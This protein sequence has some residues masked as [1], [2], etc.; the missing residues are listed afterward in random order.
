MLLFQ[1]EFLHKF[2]SDV[3]DHVCMQGEPHCTSELIKSISLLSSASLEST[4]F[5]LIREAICFCE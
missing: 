4:S 1:N 5:S 3:T 2:I